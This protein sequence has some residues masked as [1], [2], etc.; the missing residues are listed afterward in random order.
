MLRKAIALSNGQ[1]TLDVALASGV[2]PRDCG[3]FYV[4]FNFTVLTDQAQDR[5]LLVD[6]HKFALN[7]AAQWAEIGSFAMVDSWQGR[8]LEVQSSDTDRLIYYPVHTVSSSEG[9]FERTYQ[10]S[11]LM[12]GYAAAA[13]ASGI[14]L[15]LAIR[16]L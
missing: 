16:E 14:H 1:L 12:L 15:T 10:G 9:G 3:R 8:M 6:G 13:L 4:E 7:Q 5:Y 11:C 2:L